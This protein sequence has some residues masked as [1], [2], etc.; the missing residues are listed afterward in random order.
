VW[1]ADRNC[2]APVFLGYCLAAAA[3]ETAA[4]LLRKGQLPLLLDLDDTLLVA[5]TRKMLREKITVLQ[6]KLQ[7]S[8]LR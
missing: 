2:E 5:F 6:S 1:L 8:T 4:A 7:E 3:A